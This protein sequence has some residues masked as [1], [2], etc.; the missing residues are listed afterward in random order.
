MRKRVAA[1]MLVNAEKSRIKRGAT[2]AIFS[3]A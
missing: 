2:P 1:G 3:I